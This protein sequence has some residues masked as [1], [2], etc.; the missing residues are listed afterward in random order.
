M[1]TGS[2]KG[3]LPVRARGLQVRQRPPVATAQEGARG[4][5]PGQRFCAGQGCFSWSCGTPLPILSADA[6]DSDPLGCEFFGLCS[7]PAPRRPSRQIRL[8]TGHRRRLKGPQ[9]GGSHPKRQ[10]RLARRC[11]GPLRAAVCPRA[12]LAR[13]AALLQH[14]ARPRRGGLLPAPHGSA[15]LAAPRRAGLSTKRS[16]WHSREPA[17]RFRRRE[18]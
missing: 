2:T 3:T 15:P 17:K 7:G 6:L 8:N 5:L 9:D 1:L 4:T 12:G 18:R 11:S 10:Q 14:G 16:G 13:R